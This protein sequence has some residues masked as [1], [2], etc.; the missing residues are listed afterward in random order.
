MTIEDLNKV[1]TDF[2]D[3]VKG[4]KCQSNP[5]AFRNGDLPLS[6]QINRKHKQKEDSD[7]TVKHQY[8]NTLAVKKKQNIEIVETLNLGSGSRFQFLGL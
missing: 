2:R 3:Q 4:G 5:L 6:Q 1:S 7:P 8:E